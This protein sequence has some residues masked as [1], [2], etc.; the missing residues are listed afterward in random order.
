MYSAHN[1][2]KYAAAEKIIRTLKY[3]TYKHITSISKNVDNN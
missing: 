1:K 2:G 3:K